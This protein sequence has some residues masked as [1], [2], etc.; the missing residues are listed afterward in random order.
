M[1]LKL[2]DCK[3]LEVKFFSFMKFYILSKLFIAA[4][5]LLIGMIFGLMIGGY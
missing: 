1:K 2:V 4:I 5:L 3:D